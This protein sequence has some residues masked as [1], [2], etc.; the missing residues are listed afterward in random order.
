MFGALRGGGARGELGGVRGG[1]APP[2]VLHALVG[3]GDGAQQQRAEALHQG[4]EEFARGAVEREGAPPLERVPGEHGPGLEP[5]P[6]TGVLAVV[7]VF[8]RRGEPQRGG[9]LGGGGPG[10][11]GQAGV[12][13]VEDAVGGA[14]HDVLAGGGV[15]RLVDEPGAQRGHGGGGQQA[16]A[17]G[18]LGQFG[19]GE[20]GHV[21]ESGLGE[22]G[23]VL[24]GHLGDDLVGHPVQDGD[25]ADVVLL[26]GAQHVPGD[27]VGVAGGGGDHDPDVGGADEFGGQDPVVGHQGIDVGGVQEGEAGRQG[28]GG[29]DAQHAGGVLAGQEQVVRRVLVVGH[30]YAREVGQHPHAA[31]PVVVLRMADQHGRPCRRPQ[32]ARLADAPAHEG[33]HQGGL[34]GPCGAAHDGQQRRLGVFQPGHQIVVE[35]REQLVAVGTRACGPRQGQREA[36]GGDTVAQGG[37]CVEQLRP[38]VQGHHMRR[39]PNFRGILKHMSMPACRPDTRDGRGD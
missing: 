22:E 19:H 1:F 39:M 28:V 29:L 21:A 6:H 36:C 5:S 14:G 20:A 3:G 32:H 2:G 23:A 10:E 35:L 9:V 37:E 12:E 11:L 15:Q 25:Q 24:P 30:P 16:A 33:V 8:D 27:G 26:G 38:Y 4:V 34:P 17:P 13:G 7:R 18:R 31:E